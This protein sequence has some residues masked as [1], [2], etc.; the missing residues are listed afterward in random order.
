MTITREVGQP[1]FIRVFHWLF[2]VCLVVIMYTGLYIHYPVNILGFVDMRAAKTGMFI[3]VYI[4]LFLLA[5]R[6]YY[7][8]ITGDIR[9]IL[10][11]RQDIKNLPGFFKF[12]F[13][14]AE[15]EP[16]HAKYNPGQKLIFTGWLIAFGFQAVT[17]FILY[18][19]GS[20]GWLLPLFGG[21]QNIK[22]LHYL[23]FL[24][25]AATTMLHVYLT[26]SEDPAKLQAMFTGHMRRKR[27][28]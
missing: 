6:V 1:L 3:T 14:L 12:F 24:Y 13:F 23:V 8:I 5:A 20:F 11:N 9:N 22:Y 21:L 27:T 2:A 10:V 18:D 7:G 17:G 25:F 26:L 4:A 16:P 19:T 28:P 15:K